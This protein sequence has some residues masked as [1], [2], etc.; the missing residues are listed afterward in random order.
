MSDEPQDN[1]KLAAAIAQ[2]RALHLPNE[3]ELIAQLKSVGNERDTGQQVKDK[4]YHYLP[5]IDVTNRAF[6]RMLKSEN[7]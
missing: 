1:G 4:T 7:F 5:Y 6:L 2:I 3:A